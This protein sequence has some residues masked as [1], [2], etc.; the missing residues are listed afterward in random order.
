LQNYVFIT[1]INAFQKAVL[2]DSKNILKKEK[3]IVIKNI[4]LYFEGFKRLKN[5]WL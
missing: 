4:N 5:K 1:F 3:R 2:K